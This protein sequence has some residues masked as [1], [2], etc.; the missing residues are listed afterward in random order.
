MSLKGTRLRIVGIIRRTAVV[1]RSQE[2]KLLLRSSVGRCYTIVVER[3][4][5]QRHY[6]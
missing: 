5:L 1:I 2:K 3:M 4:K 6:S